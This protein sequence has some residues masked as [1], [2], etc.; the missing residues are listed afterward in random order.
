MDEFMDAAT[1]F[2]GN[3]I[4]AVLVGGAIL[5][6]AGDIRLAAL[7]KARE[8]PVRLSSFKERMTATKLNLK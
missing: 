5:L 1:G 8:G 7:R 6:I 4:S 2:I 3:L